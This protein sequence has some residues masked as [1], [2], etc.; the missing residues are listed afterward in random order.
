MEVSLG[1]LPTELHDRIRQWVASDRWAGPETAWPDAVAISGGPAWCTLL[2]PDGG[3]YCWCPWDDTVTPIEDGPRKVLEV[4]IGAK[5][6]PELAVWLPAQ[7]AG[8]LL[9][10]GC[11]GVGWRDPSG[12]SDVCHACAALGW[13]PPER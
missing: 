5:Y 13:L 1:P 2:D 3:V 4:V 8:A 6:R 12:P 7:P 10:V 11:R 9:C